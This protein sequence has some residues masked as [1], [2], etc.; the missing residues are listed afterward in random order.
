MLHQHSVKSAREG[1][2]DFNYIILIFKPGSG[3]II[4]KWCI[5]HILFSEQIMVMCLCGGMGSWEKV[6]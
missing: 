3:Y 5:P 2:G 6:P 4:T 1:T